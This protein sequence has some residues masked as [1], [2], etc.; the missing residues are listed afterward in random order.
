M[1]NENLCSIFIFFLNLKMKNKNRQLIF[2]FHFSLNIEKWK[3]KICVQF[4]FFLNWKMTNENLCS[5]LISEHRKTKTSH[6]EWTHIFS[7]SVVI[8]PTH[9]LCQMQANSSATEFLSTVSK[10]IKKKKILSLLV[11]VLHK[12]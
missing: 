6:E 11:Y 5:I 10:F 3:I 8:I 9:L 7:V 2:N 4:L 1:K 12:T